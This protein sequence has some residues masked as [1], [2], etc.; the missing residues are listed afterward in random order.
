[1]TRE[2]R[3]REAQRRW[4]RPIGR[5]DRATKHPAPSS[6]SWVLVVPVG[7]G[8]QVWR[9]GHYTRRQAGECRET[10]G[11]PT[12]SDAGLTSVFGP[13]SAV[14]AGVGLS[15]RV[16]ELR[17]S[18]GLCGRRA[19]TR[20]VAL[21]P[22]VLAKSQLARVRR[23]R[24]SRSDQIEAPSSSVRIGPTAPFTPGLATC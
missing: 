14:F 17:R 15:T 4:E 11:L 3:E 7:G 20:P 8:Y 13:G 18:P 24:Q 5:A 16:C 21:I 9:T 1:M 19:R 22:Q 23:P 2:G 10:V 6:L 12:N